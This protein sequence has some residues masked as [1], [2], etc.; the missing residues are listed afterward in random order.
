[1]SRG[2]D[3]AAAYWEFA[4]VL[5]DVPDMLDKLAALHIP[6]SSGH[7]QACTRSGYGWPSAT[8]PCSLARL[9]DLAREIRR[10]R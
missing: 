2:T 6:D 10:G 4:R 9:V 5:A 8:W 1:M 3:T 7:C